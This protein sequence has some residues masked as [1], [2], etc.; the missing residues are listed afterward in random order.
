MFSLFFCTFFSFIYSLDCVRIQLTGHPW[1]IT[2][3]QSYHTTGFVP[4]TIHTILFGSNLI[5]D[6]YTEYHDID[7]RNLVYSSWTFSRNFTLDPSFLQDSDEF[8]IS[9]T[10]IDTVANIT[11]N[12]CLIGRTNSMFVAYEF[13]VVR[14]CLSQFN[15]IRIDFDSPVKYAE[16]MARV[17]NI[18]VPPKCPPDIQHGECFI[19]FIRKEPCSFSWDWVS[20]HSFVSICRV[21]HKYSFFN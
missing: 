20:Q 8:F 13:Q 15:E 7:L 9:I 21:K 2:D 14:T 19:Q 11:L 6:P 3:Y 18:S 12:N 4:G 16:K 5:A 10:Q 17:Y 1:T